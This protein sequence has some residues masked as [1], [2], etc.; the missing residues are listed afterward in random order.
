MQ[1]LGSRNATL[2]IFFFLF[3]RHDGAVSIII[4]TFIYLFSPFPP[5]CAQTYEAQLIVGLF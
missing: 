3:L 2:I 1:R 4:S 5:P